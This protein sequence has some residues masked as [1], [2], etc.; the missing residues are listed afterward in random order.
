M[1][2]GERSR[3]G[4]FARA[5]TLSWFAVALAAMAH[6]AAGGTA[7][8]VATSLVVGASLTFVSMPLCRS[9]FRLTTHGPMLL[10][11]QLV[12]H[13]SLS[14]TSSGHG[15]TVRPTPQLAAALDGGHTLHGSAVHLQHV[16]ASSH[17]AAS[18]H[19][20]MPSP[21]MAVT[22]V[23]AALAIAVLLARAESGWVTVKALVRGHAWTAH[24]IR[25]LI[26][27]LAK[28]PVL[29]DLPALL[30]QRPAR[31]DAGSTPPPA[32]MDLWRSPAPCRRGPPLPCAA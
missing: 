20:L 18:S 7:P 16:G 11:Q 21:F 9:A 24:G 32:L 1:T 5:L 31:A 8:G 30:L 27:R 29:T 13:V 26:A 28:T 2:S 25:A 3:A 4:G 12:T 23:C 6:L 19:A 15:A 14:L 17:A 22:H 10:L